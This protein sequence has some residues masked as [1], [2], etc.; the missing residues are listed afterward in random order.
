MTQL[1]E[2]NIQW[3]DSLRVIAI[4]GVIIIHESTPV[5]K[6]SYGGN[7]GYWWIGNIWDSAVR[8]AVPLFLMLSGA[9]MLGKEYDLKTFYKKRFTRVLLLFLFWMVAY[10]VYRWMVLPPAKQPDTFSSVLLWAVNLLGSE[11]ISKHFWYVYMILFL[12]LLFPFMGKGIRSLK[13]KEILW[14]ILGWALL[15]FS[16]RKMLVNFYSWTDH[17][18]ARLLGYFQYSGYLIVGYY[19]NKFSITNSYQRWVAGSLFL[20]SIAITSVATYYYSWDARH[21]DLNMY[22]YIAFSTMLQSIAIFLLIKDSAIKNRTLLRIQQFIS[23]YSYG[24]YLSHIMVIGIFFQYNIFWTIGHPAWT[25]PAL[26]LLTLTVSL[27]IA[28]LLRKLPYG[29]YISG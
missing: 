14:L 29:K 16:S 3:L 13:N 11:G 17:Y 15:S 4:I 22:S 27:L 7:M 1:K 26:T 5:V 24:V 20:V 10:W 19:L 23:S 18:P 25:L 2:Q 28:F 9:T 21:L 8:F 12:Y 6:M